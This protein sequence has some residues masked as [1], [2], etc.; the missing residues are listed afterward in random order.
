[1]SSHVVR[2]SS[3]VRGLL[4][5]R[6][7]KVTGVDLNA[8]MIAVA[9]AAAADLAPAVDWQHA[10]AQP[11]PIARPLAD[12]VVCQQGCSSSLTWNRRRRNAPSCDL[13]PAGRLRV[14]LA[15]R[16]PL[17]CGLP[18]RD[19]PLPRSRDRPTFAAAFGL[20]RSEQLTGLFKCARFPDVNVATER[21]E[22]PPPRS[23]LL[24]PLHLAATPGALRWLPLTPPTS[25]PSSSSHASSFA[26]T[27]TAK[28]GG[29]IRLPPRDGRR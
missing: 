11:L 14:E 18:R 26:L 13:G 12:V 8:A 5:G 7:G 3:P 23:P 27:G 2:G 29:A 16:Q 21:V 15:A 4:V 10:D 17:L 25:K 1:M 22:G 19:R 28:C 6:G 24:R 9:R 20:G